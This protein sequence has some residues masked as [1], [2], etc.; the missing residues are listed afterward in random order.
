[1]H[2]MEHSTHT[3]HYGH[4]SGFVKTW[5][6]QSSSGINPYPWG[7][8]ISDTIT[9]GNQPG[10]LTNVNEI[11]MICRFTFQNTAAGATIN[12]TRPACAF[13]NQFQTNL[14]YHTREG[15]DVISM[16]ST[17]G[18]GDVGYMLQL[19]DYSYGNF[20]NN[21]AIELLQPPTA[22]TL[23]SFE[24]RV[25]F[26]FILDFAETANK[27]LPIKTLQITT[28]WSTL[29][30]LFFPAVSTPTFNVQ[31][32]GID[33]IYPSYTIT[34]PGIIKNPD[35][36]IPPKFRI[37]TFQD[38]LPSGNS[39]YSKTISCP[40]VPVK[41]LYYMLNKTTSTFDAVTQGVYSLNPNDSSIISN[42]QITAGNRSFP[43][44]QAYNSVKTANSSINV[45][46]HFD[47]FQKICNNFDNDNNMFMSFNTWLNNY[48]IYAVG[49]S[50][51]E[52]QTDILTLLTF[53]SPTTTACYL[54]F[55][56]VYELHH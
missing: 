37:F 8:N 30:Q 23:T 51:L 1:M 38:F 32:T 52:E 41:M 40:G 27:L 3:S 17:T 28:T 36:L 2:A 50:G 6:L 48:R 34:N 9:L 10:M 43:V 55:A 15:V 31:L 49:F 14:S 26:K 25:P 24:I 53:A 46:R 11:C 44:I 20:N 33:Y 13:F 5:N 21:T 19:I 47:D 12:I 22:T 42:I 4:D 16:T 45:I 54:T 35:M 18:R 29:N 7:S 39:T 56:I